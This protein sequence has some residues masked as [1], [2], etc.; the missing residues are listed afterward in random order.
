MEVSYAQGSKSSYL[1]NYNNNFDQINDV[2]VGT[3]FNDTLNPPGALTA[4]C[5]IATSTVNIN[6]EIGKQLRNARWQRHQFVHIRGTDECPSACQAYGT[7][8]IIDHKMYSNYNGL[9]VTWNKQ[10]GHFIYLAN[11]TFAKALG[12]RGEN[13]DGS[14]GAKLHWT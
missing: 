6:L 2:N 5:H 3:L 7:L 11:Y 8:K 12:I 10:Q 9:Q 14:Q 1:S 13:A 4:G